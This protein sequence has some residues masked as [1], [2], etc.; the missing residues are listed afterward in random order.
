MLD[1]KGAFNN[2]PIAEESRPYG[3]IVI[4]DGVCCYNKMTFVFNFIPDN[5]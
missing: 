4:Q 1:I 3:S 2:I 5:F